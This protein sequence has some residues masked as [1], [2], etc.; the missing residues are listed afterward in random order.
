MIP[1]LRQLVF[2]ERVWLLVKWDGARNITIW[3]A[4]SYALLTHS[5]KNNEVSATVHSSYLPHACTHMHA[6]TQLVQMDHHRPNP[7]GPCAH[8]RQIYAHMEG[9]GCVSGD[10]AY[11]KAMTVYLPLITIHSLADALPVCSSS[12]TMNF[13]NW[14]HVSSHRT[15]RNSY[16]WMKT[17]HI[18]PLHTSCFT[19]SARE[20]SPH[21]LFS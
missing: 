12:N 13:R 21:P 9:P 10:Q 17:L 19:K 18:K 1:R 14:T 5:R 7:K 15:W 11:S 4:S 20:C 2:S 8:W 3:L 6:S 16:A